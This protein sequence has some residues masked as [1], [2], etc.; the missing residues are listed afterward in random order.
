MKVDQI[1]DQTHFE[2]DKLVHRRLDRA[3]SNI[4][5]YT[6]LD[7]EAAWSAEIER[8]LVDIDAGTVELIPWDDVAQN[9][10]M[11]P[12]GRITALESDTVET[13][14]AAALKLTPAERPRLVDRLIATLGADP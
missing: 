7:V 11:S 12:K 5:S 14:E 2:D 9:C 13:L 1:C 6:R 3:R 4:G 10:L 8:R